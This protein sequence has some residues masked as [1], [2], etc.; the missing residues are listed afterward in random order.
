[1]SRVFQFLRQTGPLHCKKFKAVS[2]VY[3]VKFLSDFTFIMC[4]YSKAIFF[5]V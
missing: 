1:M 2:N 4:L 5:H 3:R